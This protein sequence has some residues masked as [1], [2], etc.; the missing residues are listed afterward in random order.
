MRTPSTPINPQPSTLPFKPQADSTKLF[1]PKVLSGP[2]VNLTV[3][4]KGDLAH[5]L[6]LGVGGN[7]GVGASVLF[8]HILDLHA[9]RVLV[10]LKVI[11]LLVLQHF[12]AELPSHWLN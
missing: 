4:D 6:P 1:P 11:Q 12:V 9:V 5:G 7:A 8:L 3:D 10:L 2:A